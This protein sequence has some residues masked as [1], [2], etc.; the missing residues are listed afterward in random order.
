MSADVLCM[1]IS[2]KNPPH[3]QA[4]NRRVTSV[5]KD[6]GLLMVVFLL[7]FKVRLISIPSAEVGSCAL[8]F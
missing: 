3:R 5:K 4:A 1:N 2:A 8:A 6:C 7:M